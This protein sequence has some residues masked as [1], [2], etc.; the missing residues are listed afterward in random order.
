MLRWILALL[1]AFSFSTAAFA[2]DWTATTPPPNDVGLYA[3]PKAPVKIAKVKKKHHR[4]HR[5]HKHHRSYVCRPQHIQ[6]GSLQVYYA[7]PAPACCGPMEAVKKYRCCGQEGVWPNSDYSTFKPGP[8]DFVYSATNDDVY[9]NANNDWKW[10]GD[11]SRD[12]L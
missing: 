11:D 5:H 1:L 9:Q 10:P 4:R 8:E 3:K 7:L 6:Q 2:L 12:T